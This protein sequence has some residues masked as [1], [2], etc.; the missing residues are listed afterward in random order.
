MAMKRLH[1][2][3]ENLVL[4]NLFVSLLRAS[5]GAAIIPAGVE[6]FPC[7][8]LFAFI[9]IMAEHVICNNG[10]S[11]SIPFEGSIIFS[12]FFCKTIDKP[13]LIEYICRVNP[14]NKGLY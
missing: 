6:V 14:D 1:R 4:A 7:L 8:V 9:A 2:T 3:G 12:I 10:V 13:I 5:A 11:G